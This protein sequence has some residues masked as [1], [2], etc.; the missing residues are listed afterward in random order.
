MLIQHFTY[1]GSLFLTCLKTLRFM[2]NL[3]IATSLSKHCTTQHHEA[4]IHHAA[5]RVPLSLCVLEIIIIKRPLHTSAMET[6]GSVIGS[7]RTG[8]L[9]NQCH[10]NSFKCGRAFITYFVGDFSCMF[11]VL[12]NNHYMHKNSA[13][14]EVIIP[15]SSS[16]I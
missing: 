8:G 10:L 7:L 12:K 3:H 11:L 15:I 1:I 6:P 5:L 4:N 9:W 16:R 14:L 2:D 13:T